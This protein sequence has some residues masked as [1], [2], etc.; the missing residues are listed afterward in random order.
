MSDISSSSVSVSAVQSLV[1]TSIAI[2]VQSPDREYLPSRGGGPVTVQFR[3]SRP[4]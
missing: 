4:Q 3:R 1:S 2:A